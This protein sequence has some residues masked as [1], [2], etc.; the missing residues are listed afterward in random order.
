[1]PPG[2]LSPTERDSRP[3]ILTEAITSL[4]ELDEY[5]VERAYPPMKELR[6]H[7]GSPEEFAALVQE[8]RP[9]GYRLVASLDT[10]G[11]A[12]AVAGFRFGR[13]LAWGRYLYV[14]DLSTMPHMRRRGHAGALLRWIETEA[15]RL[16]CTQIHLD[17]GTQ[18][19]DAH[20][21]YLGSGYV[22]SSLH[23]VKSPPE[24]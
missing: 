16:G 22:I 23:F 7:L 8:Q 1:M 10:S 15:H 3:P 21:R 13:C 6:P 5:T 19:H 17:S 4:V 18:R 2:E 14:D 11:A 20:R 24:P 12:V 9:H